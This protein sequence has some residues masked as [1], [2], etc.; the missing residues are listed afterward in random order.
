[1]SDL[2]NVKVKKETLMKLLEDRLHHWTD[3]EDYISLYMKMYESNYNMGLFDGQ[4][5]DIDDLVDNDWCNNFSIIGAGTDN[6]DELLDNGEYYSINL[7]ETLML[8]R[9]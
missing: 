7:E 6:F 2:I 9:N 3:E 8:V 1:M 5:I 4:A